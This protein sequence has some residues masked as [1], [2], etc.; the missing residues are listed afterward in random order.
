MQAFFWFMFIVSVFGWFVGRDTFWRNH[1]YLPKSQTF[2]STNTSPRIW[3]SV[4]SA[5]SRVQNVNVK[6][7]GNPA[8]E[9]AKD[10]EIASGGNILAE[11]MEGYSYKEI[12]RSLTPDQVKAINE[13]RSFLK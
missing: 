11:T 10:I 3:I 1:F 13:L 2:S 4:K 6:F 8:H 12:L 9:L 7:L 5:P